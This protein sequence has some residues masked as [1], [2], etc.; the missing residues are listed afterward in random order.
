MKFHLHT[1]KWCRN[2]CV[3][4]GRQDSGKLKSVCGS[5]LGP[6]IESLCVC[7][8]EGQDSGQRKCVCVCVMNVAIV[9]KGNTT[10]TTVRMSLSLHLSLSGP[11][12]AA[13]LTV[14]LPPS[15]SLLPHPFIPSLPATSLCLSLSLLSF[16]LSLL[17]YFILLFHPSNPPHFIGIK[18]I[19]TANQKYLATSPS[20]CLEIKDIT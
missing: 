4:V 7:A 5:E 20:A 17:H 18:S 9:S 11:P 6:A 15:P 8:C 1:R 10:T 13:G 3:C 16:L 14:S 2:V 19:S 12:W